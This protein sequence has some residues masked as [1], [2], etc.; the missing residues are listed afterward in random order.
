MNNRPNPHCVQLVRRRRWLTA[1]VDAGQRLALGCGVAT[2]GLL[3]LALPGTAQALDVIGNINVNTT[4]KKS[5][6]PVRL[7]GDVTVAGHVTLTVEPG[8]VI[9][10]AA[11]D[12]LGAGTDTSKVELIVKGSLIA[13]G[14]AADR[15]VIRGA[16][17]GPNGW[18]GISFE[19]GARESAVTFTD[20]SDAVMGI[21]S[22]TTNALS[23]SD[24][25]IQ[26]SATGL[27]WQA[28]PGPT[29]TRALI[30][31]TKTVGVLV[32]DDGMTGAQLTVTQSTV[33]N[34]DGTGLKL[35]SRIA[36]NVSRSN[37]IGN[38]IG[39]D[40]DAG[41]ALT[42]TNSLVVGN[43]QMG[44]QLN[45]SGTSEFRII[46]NT[47]D[48]NNATIT[49]GAPGTGIKVAAVSD[50]SKFILRN[51]N[52]T[53]HGTLGIEVSG[54][55]S[56]SLDHNN[57]W[58]NAANY[59]SGVMG[60]PGAISA[61]PL[62]R[63]TYGAG[64]TPSAGMSFSHLNYPNGD[65][66]SFTC[67]D[68]AAVQMYVAFSTFTT[69]G[70]CDP[71]SIVD[72]RGTTVQTLRGS[73]GAV[74]SMKV[75]GNT[76]TVRFTS[77]G[78]NTFSGFAGT[79]MSIAATALNYRLQSGSPAIDVG[80]NLDSPTGDFDGITRPTDGDMDGIATTDIGAYE[81]HMNRSPIALPGMNQIVLVNT[82]VSFDGRSSSDPDGSI[83]GYA[84]DFGDSS[85]ADTNAA[86]THKFTTL[87]TYTVKLTVTD[88]EGSTASATITITVTDNLPPIAKAGPDQK[89]APGAMVSF[90]GGAS[91][92][93]DGT[94]VSYDWNFG[95][96]TP[97]GSGR[98]VT[99]VYAT[100]GVY[101]AKLTVTDNKGATG[102]AVATITVGDGGLMDMGGGTGGSDGGTS[103]GDGGTGGGDGGGGTG[104]SDHD[105]G[106]MPTSPNGHPG[107]VTGCGCHV[108]GTDPSGT[109]AETA[110][111][112]FLLG[113]AFLLSRRRERLPLSRA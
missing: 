29:L 56:P 103:G 79:C 45:Q 1:V 88:D 51:N 25:S 65:N 4:W 50:A 92:D 69:E 106:T 58:G 2:A 94:I 99:H 7:T 53:N 23:L 83:V 37:F 104:G 89:V 27:R 46:N 86:T 28:S 70:C 30:S 17:S 109:S 24:F 108:G 98:T 63:A 60:G 49:A 8:T 77:D 73:L 76:L 3:V 38:Q 100:A 91:V 75:D 62:Y 15:I 110:A 96:S 84:W 55:V 44:L 71:V 87:G 16:T 14:T 66:W 20:I 59:S 26:N 102:S 82:N 57:V 42:L 39:I 43:R 21:Y 10:A 93:P 81:W 80:N 33:R 18:Y 90:D 68:P 31:G 36:A 72:G 95:D 12:G 54:G 40:T 6:S 112:A 111:L 52:I 113:L 85:A 41:S 5:D 11:S 35:T 9:E 107:E 97:N 13:N 105:L 101:K 78:S 32:N 48:R 34:N 22:R 61:N 47:L 67:S 74:N 64:M 19:P